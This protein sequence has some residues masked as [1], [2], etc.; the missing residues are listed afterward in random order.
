MQRRQVND[1]IK[2]EVAADTLKA[3]K[4]ALEKK[5]K[6]Y[7]EIQQGKRSVEDAHEVMIG[8]GGVLNPVKKAR[9]K[10]QLQEGLLVDFES[11]DEVVKES[12]V[13]VEEDEWIEITD[14]FGRTRTIRRS[15]VLASIE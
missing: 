4:I 2:N 8:E 6:L 5:A 10:A 12:E 1:S 14:E 9:V 7:E 13:Q 11:K 3:S 15:E